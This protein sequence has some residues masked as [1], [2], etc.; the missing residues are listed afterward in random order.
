MQIGIRADMDEALIVRISRLF[1]LI[2]GLGARRSRHPVDDAI[3]IGAEVAQKGRQHGRGLRFGIVEQDDP[4][5]GDFE[6][7]RDELQFLFPDYQAPIRDA[8]IGIIRER[9]PDF[10]PTLAAEKFAELHDIHL[11]R[12]T[13]RQWMITAGLWKDRRAR[14]KAVHQPRY[15][16]DCLGELIQI[17][18]SEHW[19][20]ESRGPRCTLLVYIDD[21]TSRLMHLQ[22]VESE[23]TFDYFAAIQASGGPSTQPA[24]SNQQCCICSAGRI[25]YPRSCVADLAGGGASRRVIQGAISV[26]NRVCVV[27]CLLKSR[28]DHSEAQRVVELGASAPIS[29][30]GPIHHGEV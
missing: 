30:I 1:Q 21:A 12:E 14:L 16:R 18:G 26:G 22:F 5:A 4:L 24:A 27:R 28:K 8:A 3:I 9:Y 10:G 15:R 13:V 25:D 11:A 23:S 17:G 20:F 7:I 29:S 6:P 2:S 19:W